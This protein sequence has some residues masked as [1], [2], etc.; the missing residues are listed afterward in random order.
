MAAAHERLIGGPTCRLT[1]FTHSSVERP[2]RA[3]RGGQRRANQG[4]REV[5]RRTGRP[6]APTQKAGRN[7]PHRH[8]RPAAAG[9]M[10]RHSPTHHV[11]QAGAG[12]GAARHLQSRPDLAATAARQQPPLPALAYRPPRHHAAA[13]QTAVFVTTG[14][15]PNR[16]AVDKAG[17]QSASVADLSPGAWD[18]ARGAQSTAGSITTEGGRRRAAAGRAGR[19][20]AGERHPSDTQ[21]PAD[22]A[23]PRRPRRIE[24]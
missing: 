2:A 3:D 21:W 12:A 22:A 9:R 19:A 16:A 14:G 8:G 23:F 24:T 10:T 15:A 7:C 11:G 4:K 6:W 18:A 13:I 5:R 1:P 17:Q 20:A